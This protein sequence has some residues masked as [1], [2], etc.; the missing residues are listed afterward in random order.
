MRHRK[1]IFFLPF[2]DDRSIIRRRHT[3]THHMRFLTMAQK[4]ETKERILKTGAGII[5]RQG[6]HHTGIQQILTE[7]GVPKGS[8][9]FYFKSKSDFGQA[10]I[11]HVAADLHRLYDRFF[12]DE[13]QAPV[14]R[15]AAYFKWAAAH[16]AGCGFT[17]GCP[18]GNLAQ[19][20]GD[21]DPAMQEK[22]AAVIDGMID[23]IARVLKEA[24]DR[25]E[26]AEAVDIDE[27]ARMIFACWEGALLH[28]KV[29]K[30]EAPLTTV[31]RHIFDRL[32]VS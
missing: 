14:D 31:R 25:G 13:T 24:R 28:M 12:T 10:L 29:V 18:I 2:I 1:I 5:Y 19:E 30:T 11:D 26:L 6:F 32:L 4:Q 3:I 27:T 17:G 23:R 15:L 8:F 16:Y 9:Y 7:S 20:M 22:L 21:L